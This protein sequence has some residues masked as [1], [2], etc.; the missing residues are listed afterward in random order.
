[1]SNKLYKLEYVWLNDED[2]N[3]IRTL[4][5]TIDNNGYDLVLDDCPM[6]KCLMLVDSDLMETRE[7]HLM[8]SAVYY[9]PLRDDS[10][11]VICNSDLLSYDEDW[12]SNWQSYRLA[13]NGRPVGFPE[14]GYPK[15]RD[16][17]YATGPHLIGRS[18]AH[19]HMDVCIESGV[20][21]KELY[22]TNKLG[23]WKYE[24]VCKGKKELKQQVIL[25]R[26]LLNVL[27]EDSKYTILQNDGENTINNNQKQII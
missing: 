2:I 13:Y 17:Q 12:Y 21:I 18:L 27:T 24:I 23:E 10:Y 14:E 16:F 6:L 3:D 15:D 8:P 4:D 11:I 5:H 20:Y 26:Y 22:H 1:M 25:S 9:N 7:V 19:E